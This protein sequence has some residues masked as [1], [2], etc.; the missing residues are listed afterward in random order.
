MLLFLGGSSPGL[1]LGLDLDQNLGQ[2]LGQNLDQNLDQDLGQD[3]NLSQI[4]GPG[5]DQNQKK[6][7]TGK[8]EIPG[9]IH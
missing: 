9:K 3:L 1:N 2:N 5:L 4:Q 7:Q 6:G 8:L